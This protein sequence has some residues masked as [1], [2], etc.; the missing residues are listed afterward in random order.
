LAFS[1]KNVF[2]LGPNGSGKSNL[3]E[4]IAFLSILRSF[5]QAPPREMIRLG[6]KMFSIEARIRT[7]YG[8]ETLKVREHLSGRRELFM[9]EN[10]VRRSSE[11]IREFHAVV[12]S[13]EDR[14]IGSGSS[15]CR[16]RFFDIL[17]STVEPE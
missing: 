5:R 13:P 3:L 12:F 16:R 15:G 9:G 7:A 2:F 1:T 17:I 10:P 6:E 8:R 11:F 4:S 14:M